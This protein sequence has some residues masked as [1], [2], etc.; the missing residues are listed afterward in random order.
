MR[1]FQNV[2]NQLNINT[3]YPSDTSQ[4]STNNEEENLKYNFKPKIAT[5]TNF[6][7]IWKMNNYIVRSYRYVIV[8]TKF[9]ITK[10]AIRRASR[11]ESIIMY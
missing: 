2:Y 9:A 1:T 10:F 7:N 11:A 8:I 3:I 6:L 4:L 5:L